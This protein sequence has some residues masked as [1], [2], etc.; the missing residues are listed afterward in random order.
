MRL[1]VPRMIWGSWAASAGTWWPASG[2]GLSSSPEGNAKEAGAGI[3]TSKMGFSC[4]ATLLFINDDMVHLPERRWRSKFRLIAFHF[5][6]NSATDRINY[7]GSG[8]ISEQWI[9]ER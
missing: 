7:P 4:V 9:G 8:R 6:S 1:E 3:G 5:R 2:M